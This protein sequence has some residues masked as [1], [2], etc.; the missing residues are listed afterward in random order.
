MKRLWRPVLRT[1]GL[2]EGAPLRLRDLALRLYR[3][4]LY[5]DVI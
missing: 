1:V 5:A 3:A 4:A 2:A